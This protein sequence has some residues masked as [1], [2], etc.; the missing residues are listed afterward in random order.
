MG[1]LNETYFVGI[2]DIPNV[3]AISPTSNLTGNKALLDII[4]ETDES[5]CLIDLLGYHLYAEFKAEFD[6]DGTTGAWTIKPGA[7]QKWKDLLNGTTYTVD[8][9]EVM[10]R[11]LIYKEHAVNVSLLSYKVFCNYINNDA[12]KY[13]DVGVKSLKAK[14][15]NDSAINAKYTASFRAFHKLTE[16]RDCYNY[17]NDGNGQIRENGT[18]SLYEFIHEQNAIDSDT[19]KNWKPQRFENQ[20][21][22]GL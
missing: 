14:H 5:E 18:R 11:G 16:Y 9:V 21:I 1:I 10:Y 8:G 6:I 15:A 12:T 20:N 2:I 19:Y 22:F 13:L 3:T 7:A 4:L 17:Y